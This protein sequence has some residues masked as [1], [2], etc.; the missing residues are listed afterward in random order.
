MGTLV[1]SFLHVLD[2]HCQQF[3]EV[4]GL[5][6]QLHLLKVT[7]RPTCV[8]ISEAQGD[9]VPLKVCKSLS[10]NPLPPATRPLRRLPRIKGS[11]DSNL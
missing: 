1:E 11:I 6:F 9:W 10:Q 8:P 4:S 5:R 2:V 3:V 7:V